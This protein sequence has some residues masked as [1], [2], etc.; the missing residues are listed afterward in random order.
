M[1]ESPRVYLVRAGKHG[2]DEDYVLENNLAMIGFLEVPSV[3]EATS[4]K[5]ILGLTKD[6]L[7]GKTPRAHGNVAGQLTAFALTMQEGDLIVLPRKIVKSQIA[8]GR[9]TGRYQYQKVKGEFRHTRSVEWTRPDSPRVT[10]LQDL[11]RSFGNRMTVCNIS[12]NQAAVR[13]R[14]VLEG[15]SDPGHTAETGEPQKPDLPEE[16]EPDLS[17]MAYD[18]IVARIQS[19]FKGHDLARLVDA[20]L[21]A[22]GWQTKIS[23]P[24][25]DG[26]ADILA[27][28]GSLGLESPRLCVQVKSQGTPTDVMV[29]RTLQGTMQSFKAEQGL[30]VCWGGFNKV[31][32][33]E[34]RQSHFIVR[35]WDSRDLVQAIYRNYEGLPA[36]IQAE[37]PME[38]V[39]ILVA[40]GA[41]E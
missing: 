9:V 38:R 6:A 23:P 11:L 5:E 24:G 31:V 4:F 36:E 37:L 19:R 3:E 29:F 22:E 41:S 39:W 40:D 30:L 34:S 15:K 2:E 8:I 13:V 27:G 32:L 1:N 28:R 10:F 21:Q 26:G 18:Q 17:Q 33:R 20:V 7:P 25:P 14:S 35:L 16:T 12:R